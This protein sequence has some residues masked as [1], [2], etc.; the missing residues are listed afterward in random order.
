MRRSFTLR[1][2]EAMDCCCGERALCLTLFIT[3]TVFSA[4]VLVY[5]WPS[6]VQEAQLLYQCHLNESSQASENSRLNRRVDD[7]RRR[8][9]ETNEEL[10][11]CLSDNDREHSSTKQA[12]W[13]GFFYCFVTITSLILAV[14]CFVTVCCW[15]MLLGVRHRQPHL[16]MIAARPQ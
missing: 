16:A 13:S 1:N 9:E 4:V 7:C 5:Y 15:S 2:E 14:G 12:F 11:Q 8:E 3:V 10:R 6:A